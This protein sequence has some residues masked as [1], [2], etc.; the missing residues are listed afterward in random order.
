MNQV[1]LKIIDVK[2]PFNT[3]NNKYKTSQDLNK[4]IKQRS[5]MLFI[6]VI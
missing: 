2:N 5:T 1:K 6:Y 3:S 4:N